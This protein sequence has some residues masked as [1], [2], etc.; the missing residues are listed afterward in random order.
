MSRILSPGWLY[1]FL[2]SVFEI[3]WALGLEF[4]DGF[5]NTV[6]TA[7]TVVSMIVSFVLLAMAVDSL[8]VGTAYA[9]WTGIGATGAVI[10]GV[11]LFDEPL[12]LARLLFI[13]LVITGVVGLKATAA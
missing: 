7:F 4:T 2:A 3:G 5:S 12:N 9:V 13:G 8:P 6:P 10:G 11:V 1:L